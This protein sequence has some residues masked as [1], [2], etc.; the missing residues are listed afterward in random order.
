[1]SGS[2]LLTE[3]S[4]LD[5]ICD[6]IFR[7]AITDEPFAH[8]IVDEALP[9]DVYETIVKDLPPAEELISMAA[10]GWKSVSRYDKH[11]T[12]ILGDLTGR[13]HAPL[14]AMLEKALLHQR[15]ESALRDVFAPYINDAAREEPVKKEARLDCG[16]AGAYLPPH[17]D[18]PIVLMKA[19]IYL[20]PQIEQDPRL[21]TA[22]YEP[23][24]PEGRIR[25]FGEHAD[26][27]VESYEHEDVEDHRQVGRVRYRPNRL[28]AFVRAINSLHGLAPLPD[29]C[30]PRYI[31]SVHFKFKR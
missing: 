11:G 26:F 6:S 7:G 19:L 21:D 22:L 14:W 13:R 8:L 18:S 4:L 15:F 16:S 31:I 24:D 23:K 25:A 3:S 5:H 9:A 28:L 29:E 27:T 1:M 2:A 12:A 10:L 17:T 30:A 20:S